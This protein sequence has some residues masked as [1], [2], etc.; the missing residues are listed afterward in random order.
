[1]NPQDFSRR[2]FLRKTAPL[3]FAS[4]LLPRVGGAQALTGPARYRIALDQD[5]LFGG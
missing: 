3:T 1:M 2:R 5:W 4:L